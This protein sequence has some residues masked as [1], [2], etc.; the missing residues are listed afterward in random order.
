MVAV[1]ELM[2]HRERDGHSGAWAMAQT[3]E[4]LHAWPIWLWDFP[5]GLR[6]VAARDADRDLI[7]ARLVRVGDADRRGGAAS[8]RA[9]R[10]A[11]QRFVRCAPTCR[12]T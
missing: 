12:C 4:R 9:A 1:M 2:G 7:G 10:S 6:V 3:G 11:R 8:G 5:D